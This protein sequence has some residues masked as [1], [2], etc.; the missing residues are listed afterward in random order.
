MNRMKFNFIE[1]VDRSN[2]PWKT[3]T[4][5]KNGNYIIEMRTEDDSYLT[6]TATF[7][8]TYEVDG[9]IGFFTDNSKNGFKKSS[10]DSSL[11]NRDDSF[12]H[13][14][15]Y[16]NITGTEW[17]VP[18]DSATAEIHTPTPLQDKDLK[19]ICYTGEYGSKSTDCEMKYKTPGT[20]EFKTTKSLAT[21]EGLTAVLALPQGTIP[22]PSQASKILRFLS[23]NWPVTLPFITFI[24]MFLL[25]YYKGRDPKVKNETIIP[26][27]TPPK[28]LEPTECGIII[29]EKINPQDITA[30]I[31]DLAIHGYI[32]IDEIE[33][34][35]FFTNTKDYKLTLQKD[36]ENSQL[37]EYE[38]EIMK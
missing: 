5:D 24:V 28:D 8:L 25:W 9:A 33:K 7:H 20:V 30:T 10:K 27:Y 3:T 35:G 16:W 36:Y 14:E 38:K 18:I 31:I 15:L 37:F 23:D 13:D 29:D 12:P 17:V 26:H 1:A 11:D 21:G 2:A 22:P 32:K 19:Y 34:K 4:Y 6:A